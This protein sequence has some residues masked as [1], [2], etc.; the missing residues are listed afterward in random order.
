[1]DQEQHRTETKLRALAVQQRQQSGACP[2]INPELENRLLAQLHRYKAEQT[3]EA[4]VPAQARKPSEFESYATRENPEE[5][6]ETMTEELRRIKDELTSGVVQTWSWLKQSVSPDSMMK[7]F[8]NTYAWAVVFVLIGLLG[9][10]FMR[11]GTAKKQANLAAVTAPADTS[12]TPSNL[13][14]AIPALPT[15]IEESQPAV[16]TSAPIVSAPASALETM[17]PP[18]PAIQVAVNNTNPA[19]KVSVTSPKNKVQPKPVVKKAPSKTKTTVQASMN[20]IPVKPTIHA[21]NSTPRTAQQ[22][23]A[24]A[25]TVRKFTSHSHYYKVQ[26]GDTLSKLALQH[27]VPVSTLR[28][29]NNIPN[30]R[31]RVG[32]QLKMP[33][34]NARNA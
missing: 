29:L 24:T 19:P 21:R 18:S 28:R 9:V 2:E 23:M 10:Y 22:K 34:K 30:D 33:T 7:I 13:V 32:Q 6:Q 17:A 11:P 1:M 3:S 31:I 15:N 12:I 14:A 5:H 25:A 16:T 8:T 26:K 4:P 20:R 27:R